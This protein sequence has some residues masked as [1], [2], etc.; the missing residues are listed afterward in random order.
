MFK[1]STPFAVW[2]KGKLVA[3]LTSLMMMLFLVACSRTEQFHGTAYPDPET[4]PTIPGVNWDS[5]PFDLADLHGKVVLIFFGYT[6]CPDV[7]PLTLAELATLQRQAGE[8]A[9]DI[10]VVFVSTDPERDTPA[11]LA[12][13]IAAF[14]PEFYAVHV[15]ADQL[16]AVKAAYGVFSEKNTEA[17]PPA[18]SDYYVDHSGYIYVV[19]KQGDL[20][21]A[22]GYSLPKEELLLDVMKLA[23]S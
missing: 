13:Y 6:Y 16:E 9:D 18:G 12:Q 8:A 22:F 15:P 7:C 21:L 17:T 5:Q 4:A 1:R 20:R 11:R 3:A 10:T 2:R 23:N 14:N 19:D